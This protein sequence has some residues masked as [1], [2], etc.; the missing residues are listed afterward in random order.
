[1]TDDGLVVEMTLGKG[2]YATTALANVVSLEQ[3]RGST[4]TLATGDARGHL[5]THHPEEG[6]DGPEEPEHS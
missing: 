3:G 1:M 4:A 2:V 5:G 6:A